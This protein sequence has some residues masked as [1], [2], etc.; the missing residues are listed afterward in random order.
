MRKYKARAYPEYSLQFWFNKT[1][2]SWNLKEVCNLGS[3]K[4]LCSMDMIVFAKYI[5][6]SK[7]LDKKDK[8]NLMSFFKYACDYYNKSLST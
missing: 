4:E 8:R 1:D 2:G 6:E 3:K 5:V 7:L